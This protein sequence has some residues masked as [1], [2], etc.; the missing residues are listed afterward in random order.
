[1]SNPVAEQARK[2]QKRG[3]G[4]DTHLVHM[5]SHELAVMEKVL[6]RPPSKN[7]HTGLPSF[8]DGG[9]GDGSSG[10]D[11]GSGNGS[12]SGG[13][14]NPGDN[15]DGGPAA[16][17]PES[18]P[19]IGEGSK[20]SSTTSGQE[21]DNTEA[22]GQ[23]SFNERG[24]FSGDL[25]GF[26]QPNLGGFLNSA[27]NEIV[28]RPVELAVNALATMTPIVG[29]FNTLASALTGLNAGKIAQN[30]TDGLPATTG[31]ASTNPNSLGLPSNLA[32]M[33]SEAVDKAGGITQ[34]AD[35]TAAN[36]NPGIGNTTNDASEIANNQGKAQIAQ[37]VDQ[38]SG[39]FNVNSPLASVTPQSISASFNQNTGNIFASLTA[40]DIANSPALQDSFSKL[41]LP[42]SM[43]SLG[44]APQTDPNQIAVNINDLAHPL[45]ALLSGN[46]ATSGA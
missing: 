33:I 17:N 19:S 8:A 11:N 24:L 38:S 4:G 15:S 44:T 28:D 26:G 39:N 37:A 13:S 35:A 10:S 34:G 21:A 16:G 45:L 30:L 9:D 27:I 14:N 32:G 23:H 41:Q 7:P 22:N 18:D 3:T 36:N 6:G 40:G 46:S 12:N 42:T 5:N 43:G 25:G 1:M 20:N 31:F 29:Q 2:I